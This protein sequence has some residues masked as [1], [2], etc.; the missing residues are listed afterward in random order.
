MR[1]CLVGAGPRGTG[2]LQRLTVLARRSG[3]ELSV[4]VVDP[5]P[6]GAG[7]IWRRDQS[8]LL[9]MNSPLPSVAMFD[10][11]DGLPPLAEW[12]A[13]VPPTGPGA[14]PA[15][16][17][18]VR[19]SRQRRFASRP[20]AGA[21]LEWAFARAAE[22]PGRVRVHRD[23]VVDVVDGPGGDQL[24]RLA[25]RAE[26]LVVDVVVLA[27]GHVDTAPA[28]DTA[29]IAAHAGA[30]GLWHRPP[31][32]AEPLTDDELPPGTPVLVRG[33]GL[34]FVDLVTLLTGGRGGRFVERG[35]G[36]LTY[37][38]SG[39][40]P[41]LYAGSR[42]GVPY[43]GK[44]GT[45][46]RA[47]PPPLPCVLTPD[48]LPGGR[49]DFATQVRPLALREIVAGHYHELHHAH[50]GRT[51]TPWPEFRDRLRE[52]PDADGVRA[53]VAHAVPDPADRFDPDRV[54]DPLAGVRPGAA[55]LQRR[56]RRHVQRD[57]RRRNDPWHSA[58][59]GAISGTVAA[60]NTT[61]ELVAAGRIAPDSVR[62]DVENSFL[63]FGS[64]LTSGPP[65]QR[66]RELLALSRAGVVRF[67]GPRLRV[68]ADDAFRAEGPALSAPVRTRHLI[69]ARLP[70]DDLDRT[71]DPLL[72]ALR[73]RG[74]ACAD[75]GTGRLAVREPDHRMLSADGRV[76][77]RR[78][79]VGPCVAGVTPV[80]GGPPAPIGFFEVN[81][82]VA[83]ELLD[84]VTGG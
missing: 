84:E 3:I 15:L 49:L 25:D 32:H 41:V 72:V 14:D 37:L 4:D 35:D 65:A 54:A 31:A 12:A 66:L 2:L 50:P 53:L 71:V 38:P 68:H 76:H 62:T 7:R 69:D 8:E 64:F 18:Q 73:S 22:G 26:P 59:I 39:R 44:P 63:P 5:F 42:R 17:A 23:R 30:R 34:T 78:F 52:A 70:A 61:L 45:T 29:A 67:L 81:D 57:L 20:V 6:P 28:A 33:L 47:A 40:E 48:A 21:Y 51:T 1:V 10:G 82:R 77:R 58:E 13:T 36:G 80:A 43:R 11:P 74:E 46:L 24:V 55:A 19:R 75:P 83:R 16:H 27:Q 60:L 56:V 9:W 79:A